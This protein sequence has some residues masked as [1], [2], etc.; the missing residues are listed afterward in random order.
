MDI[1]EFLNNGDIFAVNAGAQIVE[2]SEGYARAEMKVTHSHLNA[3]GVCQGGAIFTLADLAL[4]AIMNGRG[5]LT[6]G[7]QNSIVFLHSA[8]E[9]DTLVAEAKETCNHHKI[10]YAEVRVTNQNGE[11]VSVLTGIA[12]RTQQ[13]I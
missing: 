3:G 7:L 11:L 8:K 13:E 4:A 1:K 10:P 2:V 12:Y 5:K 6:F 9:G